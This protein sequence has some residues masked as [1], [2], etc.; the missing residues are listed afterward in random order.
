[1]PSKQKCCNWSADCKVHSRREEKWMETLFSRWG[2]LLVEG[3]S[4]LWPQ[5]PWQG[6]S[7]PKQR[8]LLPAVASCLVI[9]GNFPRDTD[10]VSLPKSTVS[11]FSSRLP[12]HLLYSWSFRGVLHP[13][14][15]SWTSFPPPSAPK[16]PSLLCPAG[17]PGKWAFPPAG[18]EGSQRD[19]EQ[20]RLPSIL[21]EQLISR[22]LKH[23]TKKSKYTGNKMGKGWLCLC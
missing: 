16:L 10:L 9:L 8:V 12:L 23:C 21:T 11:P 20:K 5:L 1:M 2:M 22:D 17:Q 15:S 14:S 4:L 6:T 7:S 19:I 3:Q 13:C 18:P